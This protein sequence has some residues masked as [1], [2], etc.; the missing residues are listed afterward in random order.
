M[1]QN[2]NEMF[3]ATVDGDVTKARSAARVVSEVRWDPKFIEKIHGVPGNTIPMPVA[4]AEYQHIE[5]HVEPHVDA[6]D[7]D[8]RL[9]GT[10]TSERAANSARITDRDLRRYG[11]HPGCPKCDLLS[12][13]LKCT[14]EAKHSDECRLRLYQAFKDH[15]DPK[16]K[17]VKE[18]LD[19][20]EV[21]D[22]RRH[23]EVI[24]DLKNSAPATPPRL[25][26][27]VHTA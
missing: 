15:G 13:G 14:W 11:F 25:Q 27:Q 16:Y 5:E 7:A 4:Q 8:R 22:A 20:L 10:E 17:L 1:A 2:S 19:S 21:S 6:D 23:Q 12:Q 3:V 18:F 9:V 26:A 24:V